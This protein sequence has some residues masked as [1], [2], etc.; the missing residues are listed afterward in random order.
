MRAFTTKRSSKEVSCHEDQE[1][2]L[3]GRGGDRAGGPDRIVGVAIAKPVKG[4]NGD[5][6]L[7][8]T[9]RHDVISATPAMTRQ[10]HGRLRRRPRGHG[11]DTVDGGDGHDF[12]RGGKGDDTHHGGP[13]GDS[14]FAE[15]GV[16]ADY[17][18]D[19]NDDLWAMAHK[20]VERK[21]GEPADTLSTARTATTGSTSAT[22]R[23]TPSPA[24]PASTRSSPTARTTSRTTAR[25]SSAARA[26]VAEAALE[27]S[28]KQKQED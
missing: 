23:P 25:S 19:G 26:Q 17:G 22:A 21:A 8:G 5:D 2:R 27:R 1:A 11:N 9:D 28:D 4:T 13:K 6:T 18:G 14:I 10:R 7:T 20:D 16:D 15:R 24:A 3:A 12:M